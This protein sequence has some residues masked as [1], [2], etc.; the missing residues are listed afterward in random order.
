MTYKGMRSAAELPMQRPGNDLIG[1]DGIPGLAGKVTSP[2]KIGE[3]GNDDVVKNNM[4][5]LPERDS[6]QVLFLGS[7]HS[8]RSCIG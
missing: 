1:G 8:E 4:F 7:S 2:G 6:C 3:N 5:A